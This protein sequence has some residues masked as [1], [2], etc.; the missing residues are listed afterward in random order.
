MVEIEFNKTVKCPW[1]EK[2]VSK[3]VQ[4]CAKKEKKVKGIIDIEIVGDKRIKSINKSYRGIDRVTDV[5]SFAWQEDKSFQSN[6]LG[7]IFVSYPTIVRQAKAYSVTTK[8]EFIRMLVHGL[9]HLVGYDHVAKKDAE[10]MFSIQ[11]K[12]VE[13]VKAKI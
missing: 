10:K 7:Q 9:L 6:Y 12:I 11:E 2:K 8:E 4:I 13:G 3:I 1:T 5:L